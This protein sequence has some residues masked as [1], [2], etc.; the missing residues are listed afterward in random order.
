VVI[1]EHCWAVVATCIRVDAYET[2]QQSRLLCG[3]LPRLAPDS[4]RPCPARQ[5]T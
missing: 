1:H 5:D 2:Y 3:R 4:H